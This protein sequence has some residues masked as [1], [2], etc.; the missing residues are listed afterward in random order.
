MES[1]VSD[2]PM[3]WLMIADIRALL[4]YHLVMAAFTL[5]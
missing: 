4:F 3:E 5:Q 1:L 2:L